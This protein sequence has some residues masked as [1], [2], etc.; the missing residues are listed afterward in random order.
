MHTLCS[1]VSNPKLKFAKPAKIFG[2]LTQK[3]H[4]II[5]NIKKKKETVGVL[6]HIGDNIHFIETPGLPYEIAKLWSVSPSLTN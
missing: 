6:D 1:V 2:R 3:R 5:M 4:V